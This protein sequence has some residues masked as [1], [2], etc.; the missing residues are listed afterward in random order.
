MGYGDYL[1]ARHADAARVNILLSLARQSSGIQG[2]LD[3]L[4]ALQRVVEGPERYPNCPLVLS[5]IH[6]SK[7]LEYDRVVLI[8]V[9]DGVF[10][11]VDAPE[12]EGSLSPEEREALEEERRLFY[13]GVTRAKYQ[14][15]LLTY[16][17]RFGEPAPGSTFARQLLGSVPSGDRAVPRP[18]PLPPPRK[19]P[20]P[21]SSVAL[22][23][24]DYIPGAAVVHRQFGRGI[25]LDKTGSIASVSFREHG[26]KKLDLTACLRKGLIRLEH[27]V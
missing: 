19:A 4:D 25:L 13:V 15:E 16:S 20:P 8:D 18:K 10:P 22:W 3:R 7:G 17:A 6:S 1:S 12:E 24:K 27:P 14:L 26:T 21:A 23:E 2:L 11:A 9:M 5:T